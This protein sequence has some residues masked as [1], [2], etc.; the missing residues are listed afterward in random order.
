MEEES[1]WRDQAMMGTFTDEES[2]GLGQGF[3]NQV[4]ASDELPWGA[5]KLSGD[6]QKHPREPQPPMRHLRRLPGSSRR[7]TQRAQDTP[8]R[9]PWGPGKH[10]VST[11]NLPENSKGE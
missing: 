1:R 3:M 8:G 9:H 4:V 10:P 11:R 6:T 2:G 7:S 5:M